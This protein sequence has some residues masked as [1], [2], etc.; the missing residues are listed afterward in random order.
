MTIH[1]PEELESSVR[2]LVRGGRFTSEDEV[3][4]EALRSFFRQQQTTASV[5]PSL[6]SIG[7]MRDAAEELDGIVE[8][9]MR[10][11]QEEPWRVIPGA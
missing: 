3:I 6:G 4:A 9:A 1:L 2:S 10:K 11:R 5:Q 7:A 8:D